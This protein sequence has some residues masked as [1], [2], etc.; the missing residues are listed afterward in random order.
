MT[1]KL[2][3]SWIAILGQRT[4]GQV[5]KGADSRGPGIKVYDLH[6]LQRLT[7]AVMNYDRRFL[8]GLPREKRPFL[9]RGDRVEHLLR[10]CVGG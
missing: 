5:C 7:E 3:R 10:S 1:A 8:A 2:I 6:G 9:D 4:G